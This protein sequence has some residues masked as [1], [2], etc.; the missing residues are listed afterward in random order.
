[1]HIAFWNRK[2]ERHPYDAPKMT[3]KKWGVPELTENMALAIM[4]YENG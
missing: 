2:V 1:M 3:L 4:Q